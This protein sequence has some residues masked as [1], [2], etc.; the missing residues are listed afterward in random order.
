MEPVQSFIDKVLYI[1]LLYP[2][3]HFFKPLAIDQLYKLCQ[4]CD[5]ELTDKVH[6][7]FCNLC[8]YEKI[9]EQLCEKHIVATILG[10]FITYSR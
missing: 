1:L 7:I 5:W 8:K 3:P 2:A 10:K 4:C 9:R 6:G